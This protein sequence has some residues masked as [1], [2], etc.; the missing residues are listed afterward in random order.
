V[1]SVL[2]ESMFGE[3]PP[4]EALAA[5]RCAIECAAASR[6]TPAWVAL[7]DGDRRAV[8]VGFADGEVGYLGCFGVPPEQRRAGLGEAVLRS[9]LAEFAR[10]G[11]TVA[12]SETDPR[13]PLSPAALRRVGFALDGPV[14]E[15]C[16]D[17]ATCRDC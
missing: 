10:R 9:Q 11:C 5:A 14:A 12:V 4:E 7:T 1:V 3:L 6:G 8:S 16:G 15:G 13:L 2:A 17:D